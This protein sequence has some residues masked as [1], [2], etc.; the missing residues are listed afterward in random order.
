MSKKNNQSKV[1]VRGG[2]EKH[3]GRQGERV[4]RKLWKGVLSASGPGLDRGGASFS[5]I[6]VATFSP[7][8]IGTSWPMALTSLFR[9]PRALGGESGQ[10]RHLYTWKESCKNIWRHSVGKQANLSFVM[11]RGIWHYVKFGASLSPHWLWFIIYR[12]LYPFV[13]NF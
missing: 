4:E 10:E 13:G 9:E 7:G 3:W 8:S 6:L 2:K 5:Q 12:F 1:F 11:N